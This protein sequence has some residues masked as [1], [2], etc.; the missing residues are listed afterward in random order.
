MTNFNMMMADGKPSK[1]EPTLYSTLAEIPVKNK[2]LVPAEATSRG[3]FYVSKQS[4]DSYS[5]FDE[6]EAVRG[7][8]DLV[9]ALAGLRERSEGPTTIF[10]LRE[11]S[12]AI[13]LG[14][15]QF[16]LRRRLLSNVRKLFL[17]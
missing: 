14:S 4:Q 7:P 8:Q 9:Y 6:E 10:C 1:Q 12:A 3:S 11:F 17:R 13:I 2:E 16:Q 15:G 5:I